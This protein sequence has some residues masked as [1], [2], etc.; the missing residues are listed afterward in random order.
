[1]VRVLDNKFEELLKKPN[2]REMD[3]AGRPMK[4]FLYVSPEGIKTDKNLQK[5]IDLGLE[6]SI[7][8]P[9]KKKKPKKTKK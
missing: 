5:W 9:P 1:M 6:Y 4:G 8:S 7:K 3:F 2:A